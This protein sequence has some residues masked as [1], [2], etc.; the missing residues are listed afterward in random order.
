M[1][2]WHYKIVILYRNDS[3][4]DSPV[5]NIQGD[6][7]SKCVSS[8][9]CSRI[10]VH[11]WRDCLKKSVPS[12]HEP[13]SLNA[14]D[15]LW[16]GY[17]IACRMSDVRNLAQGW[18]FHLNLHLEGRLASRK[19]RVGGRVEPWRSKRPTEAGPLDRATPLQW[20]TVIS[21]LSSLL[22]AQYVQ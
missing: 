1:E 7:P 8:A 20:H 17:V 14:E 6:L 5:K 12:A 10:F 11:L 3:W 15:D 13:A 16:N 21:Q 19:R 9:N 2:P 22:P 18:L 4:Q